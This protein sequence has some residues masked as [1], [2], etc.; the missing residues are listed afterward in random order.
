M[1]LVPC[2]GCGLPRTAEDLASLPCPLCGGE[3]VAESPA[4]VAP[5]PAMTIPARSPARSSRRPLWLAVAALVPIAGGAAVYLAW[6]K[7][8]AELV[9]DPS[10]PKS[11]IGVATVEAAP[12]PRLSVAVPPPKLVAVAK[13]EVAPFPRVASAP[14]IEPNLPAEGAVVLNK[15]DG[16][17]VL[18]MAGGD[19]VI[20]LTGEVGTLRIGPVSGR[21]RVD[22]SKL[23]AKVVVVTGRVDEEATLRVRATDRIEFAERVDGTATVTAEALGGTVRFA[24]A[25]RI[26]GGATVHVRA[27]RAEFV[28]KVDGG[29]RLTVDAGNGGVAFGGTNGDGKL[30]GGA[31]VA[32]T[33]RT[34]DIGCLMAGEANVAV[35]VVGSGRI[36]H[37][38]LEGGAKLTHRKASATNPDPA[39]SGGELRGG[40]TVSKAE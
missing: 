6:P 35:T 9:A 26:D 5:P 23:K 2:P 3:S 40:A 31:R 10:K 37:K 18:P 12:R 1:S 11:S 36:T 34:V 32:V 30:G 15:P 20:V 17:Y 16:E 7:S 13:P 29:S 19:E 27:A 22:A 39:V 33:A 28:G 4:A 21:A 25:A 38:D 24:T 8:E 14:A